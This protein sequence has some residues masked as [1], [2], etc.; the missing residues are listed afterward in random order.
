MTFCSIL[1]GTLT[2][3]TYHGVVTNIKRSTT[4]STGAAGSEAYALKDP[5]GY[6]TTIANADLANYL[7]YT[8]ADGSIVAFHK[9][10]Q[11]CQ[12]TLG[13]QLNNTWIGANATC[14]GFIDVNGPLGN[15][16]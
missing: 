8:L 12:L 10:A 2:G 16:P 5:T 1:N 15:L 11:G 4:A 7:A 6:T 14:K 13:S 3:Q 9:D